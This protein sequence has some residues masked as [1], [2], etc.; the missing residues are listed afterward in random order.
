MSENAKENGHL[1]VYEHVSLL[2]FC[3]CGRAQEGFH[4][5]L[6][7]IVNGLFHLL[8]AYASYIS[9]LLSINS[10]ENFSN[11]SS[12]FGTSDRNFNF[13][14]KNGSHASEYK[15]CGCCSLSASMALI[16]WI[17]YY[18]Q[19]GFRF[20]QLQRSLWSRFVANLVKPYCTTTPH[21]SNRNLFPISIVLIRD[22]VCHADDNAIIR[23]NIE[24]PTPC[25]YKHISR[26]WLYFNG[27]SV[28]YSSAS[29]GHIAKNL[30]VWTGCYTCKP[31]HIY[32]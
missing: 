4:V 3:A 12:T 2:S 13:V 15:G 18:F 6:I 23:A 1:C 25:T 19:E 31:T 26:E 29:S 11:N 5:S 22:F 30:S 8:Y 21:E 17:D 7:R 10:S 16:P 24:A 9:S 14:A 27:S 32:H 20:S 28:I